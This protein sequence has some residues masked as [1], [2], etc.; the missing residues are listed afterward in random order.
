MEDNIVV[1]RL[2]RVG[3]LA[4]A[5]EI[6]VKHILENGFYLLTEN[7]EITIETEPIMIHVEHPLNEPSI[8][9]YSRFQK[10]FVE[11]YAND[12]I[13]GT[14][15]DFEYDY[16]SRLCQW[17]CGFTSD[18]KTVDVNQLDYI[19]QKLKEE[20]ESRRAIAITWNPLIDEVKK[21]C[22]CLQ[23]VQ[24]VIR[25]KK[26]N[27]R[28]MFRSNDMLS[29]LGSNMYALVKMQKSLADKLGVEMGSYTHISTIPHIYCKRDAHDLI[30]F[31]NGLK[32]QP[33]KFVC[34]SCGGCKN[35]R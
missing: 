6:I 18:G 14:K 33:K 1:P 11:K 12:L 27:M 32:I 5:H 29:A 21:D 34:K 31:C 26:L 13:N 24:C 19:V 28:V 2:F 15:S 22:P 7:D 20:P 3:T 8:S 10:Q 16:H 30:P 9:K 25:N 35:G 17:G 23:F 4:D